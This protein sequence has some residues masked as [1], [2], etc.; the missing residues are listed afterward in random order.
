VSIGVS[1]VIPTFNRAAQLE[2]ALAALSLQRTD[3]ARFEVVVVD[4]GS[5]DSTADVLA[6]PRPYRLH[7]LRQTNQGPGAARNAAIRAAVGEIVVFIDDDVVPDSGLIEAH[8]GTQAHGP[9]VAIGPMLPPLDDVR[10]P[11]WS[12]W[13]LRMLRKQYESML[14]GR[15]APTPRQ[16]YTANASVP[17]EALLRAGLFDVS[18]LRAEDM[19]L[20]Y[21]LQD[22]G[23]PFRFVPDAKVVHDTPRS[24]TS[25][26]RL[27][28]DYGRYDVE[29]SRQ[30][31]REQIVPMMVSEYRSDRHPVLRAAARLTAGRAAPMLGVR[32][33]GP[34]VIRGAAMLGIERVS[35]AACSVVFNLQYWDAVCRS[36]GRDAWWAAVDG[37]GRPDERVP[38]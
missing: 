34:L 28:A 8:L 21:R 14:T 9:A 32:A 35:F 24:L 30:R 7:A 27:G 22:A 26:L 11:V 31:H 33:A 2:R 10:Q 23:L 36:L 25:W 17:R 15:W 1:V 29:I 3:P 38:A 5:N 12:A 4:D 19:E 13:E 16:F 37:A 20:A 18:F 6:R